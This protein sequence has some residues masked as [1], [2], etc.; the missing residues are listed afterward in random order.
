MIHELISG[1]THQNTCSSPIAKGKWREDA[2][3]PRAFHDGFA[4]CRR[5]LHSG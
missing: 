4:F 1:G 5:M 2:R 3:V